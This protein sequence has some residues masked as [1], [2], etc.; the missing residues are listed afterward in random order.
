MAVLLLSSIL[1]SCSPET[2]APKAVTISRL[3]N[4]QRAIQVLEE[5]NRATIGQQLHGISGDTTL[6]R[7]W[8]LLLLEDA[9]RL[10]M[11][12][13]DIRE[14]LCRDGY[15][16][17]LNVDFTTNVVAHGASPGLTSTACDVVV[18]SSGRNGTNEFGN[19]DDVVWSPPTASR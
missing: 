4:V 13:K 10:Q 7:K 17:L 12:E 3:K 1:V 19:G 5:A 14:F 9:G 15:G 11:E 18:W 2:P 16:N 6:Q 8:E